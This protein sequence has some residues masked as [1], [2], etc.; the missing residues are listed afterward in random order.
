MRFCS[1]CVENIVSRVC[2]QLKRELFYTI[3]VR[4]QRCTT[5]VLRLRLTDLQLH[6]A[7]AT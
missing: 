3:A 1:F 7:A 5:A 6:P 4:P 2:T